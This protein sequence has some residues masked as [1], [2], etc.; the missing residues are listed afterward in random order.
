MIL[1]LASAFVNPLMSSLG[2][3]P[4]LGF[5]FAGML[6][7]PTGLAL[8]SDYKATTQLAELGVVFFLFEMG[9]E[10]ELEQI[11][12]VGKDAFR[13]GTSQFVLTSLAIGFLALY[14]GASP[15]AAIVLGGGLALS[16]SAFVIQL[17]S[18]KEELATRFGRAAF[19]ILLFQDLAVVPLLVVTPLLGGTGAALASALRSAAVKSICTLSV[20]FAS[21]RLLLNRVFRLVASAKDQTSFL[22]ITLFTV[23]SMSAFTHAVGLSDTLGAFLAG[24]LLAETKFRYQIEADIAP[25]RGI[26]LG[27][28]F[29]TTGFQID[30]AFAAARAPLILGLAFSLLFLK[31]VITT[32]VC[33]A[34]G[35]KKGGALRSGLILSQ[36]GEFAFVLFAL[37]QAHG[38]LMPKQAKLL[39]TMVVLTM[40]LTPFLNTLGEKL[41]QKFERKT[42]GGILASTKDEREQGDYVL[43]LGYGRVGKIVCGLLTSK[44]IRYK[45]FDIDPSIVAEAREKGFP[46]FVGDSSRPEVLQTFMKEPDHKIS[47]IVV[48]LDK[49]SDATRVVRGLLRRD[50]PDLKDLPVLV[51][52]RNDKHRRKM[53]ALGAIALETGPEESSL[54]L[55]G[56]TLLKLG[57]KPEEVEVLVEEKRQDL[58]RSWTESY[59]NEKKKKKKED[60]VMQDNTTIAHGSADTNFSYTDGP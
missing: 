40:F 47:A 14:F 37:A 23:L 39:L 25:F 54:M 18:E 45:A 17:L 50:D 33:I 20:I 42:P 48:T 9:L 3:S 44:L 49:E 52:A 10:L 53:E 36:G 41:A 60:K 11:K 16:S 51:R 28:F 24:V 15:A 29:I 31:T 57:V 27:L 38:I 55:G 58:L 19:G 7:G 21:G 22:A 32:F 8:V 5:L 6:L 2:L 46:V 1:L 35:L 4:V 12:A 43:V 34:G 59:M 13:L 56:T 26:L 30:L